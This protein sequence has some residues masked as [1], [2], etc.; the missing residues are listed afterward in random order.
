MELVGHSTLSLRHD[1]PDGPPAP[2]A[3]RL[4]P[5]RATSASGHRDRS[6][7]PG[8]HDPRSHNGAA[9][10]TRLCLDVPTGRRSE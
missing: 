8:R 9:S 4:F 10:S 7:S 1:R 3:G 5:P 2:P 6:R